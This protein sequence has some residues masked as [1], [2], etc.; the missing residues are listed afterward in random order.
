[1]AVVTPGQLGATAVGRDPN[2]IIAGAMRS[3]TTSLHHWL[4]A[5]PGVSMPQTKEVHYFDLHY[6]RGRNWYREQFPVSGSDVVLGE[7]TPEYLFLPWAR[8]RMCRDLPGTRLVVTLRNPVDRA[9][10]HYCM[11]RARGREDLPFE[12][13]LD[14]EA[15]RMRADTAS[16]SRYGYA[17]KGDYADQ[18]KDL[19]QR[20]GRDDVLV[21][22]FERDVV[23]KPMET[24]RKVCRFIGVSDDVAVAAVGSTVNAAIHV[25]SKRVRD[26]ARP[27]PKRVRDAVGRLNAA[28]ALNEPLPAQLRD[29]L[30]RRFTGPNHQ[31]EELLG[32]DIPEWRS[33]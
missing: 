13:A 24:F 28:P 17:S 21:L 20:R 27:F 4:R 5:H 33:A 25:R 14:Q 7:S 1:M 11:L 19:F 10:S 2:F 26:M 29:R 23:S 16:W 32:Q 30:T 31:L 12:A 18:L 15:E 3:G 6:G 9:W 8:E 22:I